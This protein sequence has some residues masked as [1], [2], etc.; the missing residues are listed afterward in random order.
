MGST[1]FVSN[2]INNL[3]FGI[4]FWSISHETLSER[5]SET[6]GHDV[7]YSL[8]TWSR[9]RQLTTVIQQ[10]TLRHAS[11]VFTYLLRISAF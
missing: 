8:A 1:P 6:D 10:W 7:D 5:T 11:R 2:S 9:H 3:R 4:A